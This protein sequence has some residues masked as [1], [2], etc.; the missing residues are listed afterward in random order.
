MHVM[1][2]SL[3]T[4]WSGSLGSFMLGCLCFSTFF[5]CWRSSF[6]ANSKEFSTCSKNYFLQK[7]LCIFYLKIFQGLLHP[8]LGSLQKLKQG[9]S[10]W[11]RED[12]RVTYKLKNKEEDKIKPEGS[13]K[14]LFAESSFFAHLLQVPDV[15][16]EGAN[17]HSRGGSTEISFEIVILPWE[18]PGV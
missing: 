6:K 1:F 10:Y 5:E 17:P 11:R 12:K 7:H 18:A 13:I 4:F 14:S 16:H 2:G 9:Q 3:R 15:P 8:T